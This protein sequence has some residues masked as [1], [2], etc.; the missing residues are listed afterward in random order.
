MKK[1]V[2]L[3]SI[4]LFLITIIC[5]DGA[6]VDNPVPSIGLKNFSNTGCKSTTRAAWS[7]DSYFELKATEGNMLY[8]KHVNAI[9]NCASNKFD[10]KVEID[11]NSITIKEYDLTDLNIMMSCQCPFDLGYEIGPLKDGESYSIKVVSGV[12]QVDPDVVPVTNEVGFS[13][14]YSPSFT[15]V[16]VPSRDL[17][18]KKILK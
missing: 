11:G 8:V 10:A 14:V 13:I 4:A 18:S 6:S 7:D 9:F 17:S 3:L 1:G 16:I 2:C 12:A 5:C 15:E